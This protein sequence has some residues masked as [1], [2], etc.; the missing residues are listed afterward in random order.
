MEGL[1]T[2]SSDEE[3]DE[4]PQKLVPNKHE[5]S[6]NTINTR[7][8]SSA[9]TTVNQ[10]PIPNSNNFVSGGSVPSTAVPQN[11]LK[12]KNAN[13]T[14][15]RYDVLS[16]EGTV[17]AYTGNE[18]GTKLVDYKSNL[19]LKSHSSYREKYS[20]LQIRERLVS[21]EKLDQLMRGKK[22][23]PLS[24]ARSLMPTSTKGAKGK[25][26][27]PQ[28][29]EPVVFICL[30]YEKTLPIKSKTSDNLYVR[31]SFSDLS[32]PKQNCLTLQ[33][34]SDAF[35]TWEENRENARTAN[36]GSVFG[37]LMPQMLDSF[38]NKEYAHATFASA[39]VTEGMQL[40]KIGD[41]PS[42][43]ICSALKKDSGD[44]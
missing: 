23:Q 30:L 28:N 33:L 22:F 25:G 5:N 13:T 37:I 10:K 36:T 21:N 17:G 40:I 31:W 43:A 42:L 41:F 1:E 20:G 2:F 38:G 7:N 24:S 6:S 9:T 26:K 16:A 15:K 11:E 29:S 8:N 14:T 19:E 12:T 4:I 27:A 34:F 35:E 3:S 18:L 32:A 39:R 44:K